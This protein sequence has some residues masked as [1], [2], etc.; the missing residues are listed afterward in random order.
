MK[1]VMVLLVLLVLVMVGLFAVRASA[2]MTSASAL[3]AVQDY[4]GAEADFRAT[5]TSL[6]G[7]DAVLCQSQIGACVMG[8]KGR[9]DD[10][11][12]EFNKIAKMDGALPSD[13][14]YAKFCVGICYL[15]KGDNTTGVAKFREE[16]AD[17]DLPVYSVGNAYIAI[18]GLL[19]SQG[20][21]D[22][23]LVEYAKVPLVKGMPSVWVSAALLATADTLT[24]QGKTTQ[25]QT[26]YLNVCN[27]G[28]DIGVFKSAFEKVD[29]TIVG[30]DKY[31]T[32]LKNLLLAIPAKAENAEFLGLIKSEIEKLK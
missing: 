22:E 11:I 13:I 17:P 10:A 21:Y 28:G 30:T 29:P 5:L 32:Y 26:A 15:A 24:L 12:V 7:N 19:V 1:K 3:L 23:A 27:R 9:A 6:K 25:A 20:K 14:A 16:I 18:G 31:V 8:Q 4:V 2:D